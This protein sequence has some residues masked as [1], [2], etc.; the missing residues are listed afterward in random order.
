MSATDGDAR[1][2]EV[3]GRLKSRGFLIAD[4]V[5][6]DGN[7]ACR[8]AHKSRFEMRK[9]GHVDTFFVFA[10][11]ANLQPRTIQKFS[12]S[13]LKFAKASRAFPL[14]CG[15]FEGVICYAIAIVRSLCKIARTI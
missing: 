15:M 1:L 3:R 12:A 2:E 7:L 11:F 9:F 6:L 4:D 13:A 14:P 10:E 8:V 5:T